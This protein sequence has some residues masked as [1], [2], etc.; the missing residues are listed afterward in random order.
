MA[1]QE[2]Q[3][4]PIKCA[5]GCGFFGNPLTGNF[6]SKCYKD[7]H[8]NKVMDEP[9]KMDE[10]VFET[11][12]E[13]K[14]EVMK[15]DK[16]PKKEEEKLQKDTSRC[17]SCKRKVGL[18]GFRCRCEVVFCSKHRHAEEHNCTY[19]YRKEQ[20]QKLEKMN[21]QVVAAKVQKL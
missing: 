6:C 5:N 12:K 20:Q 11:K 15:E 3:K 8:Q 21:P 18:L 1:E 16:E 14:F 4:N 9:K 7:M 10:R 2:Q 19:D 13:D 17:W